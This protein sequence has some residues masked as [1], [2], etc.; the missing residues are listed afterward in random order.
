M[1]R[2]KTKVKSRTKTKKRLKG[3]PSPYSTSYS[4]IDTCEGDGDNSAPNNEFAMIEVTKP[5]TAFDSGG[6]TRGT[7]EQSDLYEISILC[8][9]YK[10]IEF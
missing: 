4:D 1:K 5:Q 10:V 7:A 6:I 8:P 9:E 2:F 3:E